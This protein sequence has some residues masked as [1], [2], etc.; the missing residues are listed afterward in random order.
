MSGAA[1]MHIPSPSAGRLSAHVELDAG[2]LGRAVDLLK[3]M[4]A[5]AQ[6]SSAGT[7]TGA[8]AQDEGFLAFG[9]VKLSD[10]SLLAP[11]F[12]LHH[13]LAL[14]GAKHGARL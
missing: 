3:T 12:W 11:A 14:V 2:E 1:R 4:L 6:A 9:D 10:A 8:D 7:G 5:S 13:A